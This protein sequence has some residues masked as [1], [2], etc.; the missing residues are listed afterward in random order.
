MKHNFKSEREKLNQRKSR[1]YMNFQ[2]YQK[3]YNASVEQMKIDRI[4]KM[5]LDLNPEQE[6]MDEIAKANN[7]QEQMNCYRI[8]AAADEYLYYIDN[9][10]F[11]MQLSARHKAMV[12]KH[13]S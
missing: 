6:R 7:A 13:K 10:K 2:R 11:A 8:Q 4:G 3:K 1:K 5:I 9:E 12:A